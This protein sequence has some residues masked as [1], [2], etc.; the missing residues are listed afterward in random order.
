MEAKLF[1]QSFGNSIDSSGYLLGAVHK[2]VNAD[3]M[4]NRGLHKLSIYDIYEFIA[5]MS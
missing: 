5:L 3:N 4:C 2:V 1:E